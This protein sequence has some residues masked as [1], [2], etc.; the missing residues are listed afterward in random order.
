MGAGGQGTGVRHRGTETSEAPRAGALGL[1][2]REIPGKLDAQ[3][4]RRLPCC[5]RDGGPWPS[6]LCLLPL[7]GAQGASVTP[8]SC[9]KQDETQ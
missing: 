4:K 7:H 6:E 9:K 1:P 3:S 8:Q 2:S 5:R